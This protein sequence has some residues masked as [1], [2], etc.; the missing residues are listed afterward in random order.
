MDQS[1]VRFDRAECR[2]GDGAGAADLAEV[3]ADQV[4]DHHVLR[5]VLVPQVLGHPA[6]ALDGA[7]L[8]GA[9]G[10]AQEQ[11]GGS[12]GDLGAV[13]GEADRAR[14]RGRVAAGQDGGQRVDVGARG[15]GQRRAE[16][17]AEV[18]LIDLAGGYVGAYAPYALD[19]GGAVQRTAPVPG[20]RAPPAGGVG[21]GHRPV[22]PY[23]PEARAEQTALVVGDDG[24]PPRRVQGLRITGDIAQ[25]SGCTAAETGQRRE[26]VH[27][28]ESMA[29]A[30][31]PPRSGEQ[32]STLHKRVF[33][34]ARESARVQHVAGTRKR[35]GD[36]V[37]PRTW[38]GKAPADVAQLVE[39]HLAK[40]DVASSSL[41]VRSKWGIFPTPALLVE[42][43]RGE[44][45]ACKAVYTG[46]NPVSTSKDD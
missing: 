37:P 14:V 15:V 18:H 13:R 17:P 43:P 29:G 35:N 27:A 40:V 34:L 19:V 8:D 41:V 4:D 12:G 5:P 1:G 26:V 25:V 30:G 11:F 9:P 46:S 45:T 2:D 16:N 32:R 20:G 36:A 21:R 31:R 28:I 23:V 42:W 38:S 6:G 39:H 22:L 44:A 3:V 24:P 33:V 10:A 7:G